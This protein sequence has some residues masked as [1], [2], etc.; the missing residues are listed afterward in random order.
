M[1]VSRKDM[2]FKDIKSLA[3]VKGLIEEATLCLK[4]KNRTINDSSIS[5]ALKKSLALGLG[6]VTSFVAISH[7]GLLGAG[8]MMVTPLA[9][10]A[11]AVAPILAPAVIGTA[12]VASKLK[13]NK[14]KAE[15]EMLY[16]EAVAKQ[17]AIINELKNQVKL[18]QERT[19][20][21]ES[22]NIFLT[23]CIND[24][25]HDLGVA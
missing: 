17:N 13:N 12:L 8:T 16:A 14:L 21:L 9:M 1:A 19:D 22:L 10:T 18:T 24:L 25:K 20:Y 6:S 3:P 5:N 7:F 23:G 11:T 2:R 15:K 4:D